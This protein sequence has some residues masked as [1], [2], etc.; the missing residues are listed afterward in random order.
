V[1]AEQEW[2]VLLLLLWCLQEVVLMQLQRASC[3]L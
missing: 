2:Q 3:V 1:P